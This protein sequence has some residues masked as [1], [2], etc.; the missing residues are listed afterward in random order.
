MDYNVSK[1]PI[2]FLANGINQE[3]PGKFA[4]V[5]DDTNAVFGVVGSNYS[6]FQNEELFSFFEIFAQATGVTLD[7]CGYI[8]DGSTVWVAATAARQEFLPGDPSQEYFLIS[9]S[10]DGRGVVQVGFIYQR[11][12][13]HNML[14][15]SLEKANHFRI[16]HCVNMRGYLCTVN[17][18][19]LAQADHA[20]KFAELMRVLIEKRL[21][22]QTLDELA[23]TLTAR[24]KDKWA[25]E[26]L[27]NKPYNT[28]MSLVE[29]GLG[30]NIP[31][32]RGSAYGFVQAVTEYVDHY[33]PVRPNGREEAEARLESALFGPG[34]KLKT[35][36]IEL[37]LAA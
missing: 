7:S 31:G 25:P 2:S 21:T 26:P 13:C 18:L 14:L 35:Q 11:L 20:E 33:R 24:P 36:A 19:M 16:K 5:R 30:A 28:I 37:A 15:S 22:A 4:L 27:E 12:V 1:R 32:V 23:K 10:H 34:A 9:N 17:K 8:R 29:S 3:V 6:L